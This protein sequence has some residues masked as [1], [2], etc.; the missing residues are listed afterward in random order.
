MLS[1]RWSGRWAY[2]AA[3]ILLL[4][5]VPAVADE[6]APAPS[7]EAAGHGG[8]FDWVAH[9]QR[10]LDELKAKLNLT[11]GQ[12]AA[13]D[14]WAAGVVK[15]AHHQLE[16][17]KPWLEEKAHPMK[18]P[19][20]ETTPERMARGIERLRAQTSWMQDHLVQ[21]EAAQARTKVFYNSL[22]KNQRTIF[23]LFW[24]E[25]HHRMSGHDHGWGMHEQ[26][27]FGPEAMGADPDSPAGGQ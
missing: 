4:Q 18:A 3:G 10:T 15:D 16:T 26:Q 5:A 6:P 19:V 22:D 11:P 23:D 12:A 7:G 2:V 9:T 25:M 20:D 8:S 17:K 24:H 27:D 21:L 14:T 1:S 13:W